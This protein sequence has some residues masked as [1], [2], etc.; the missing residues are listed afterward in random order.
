M[1]YASHED[2]KRVQALALRKRKKK[3]RDSILDLLGGVCVKCGFSDPR[4]LAID[5]CNGGGTAERKKCGGGYYRVVLDKI[6]AGS[7]DYQL[8]CCN[9]NQIKKVES[10]EERARVHADDAG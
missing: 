6:I 8:L 10:G 3:I 2:R 4:A 9:C 1:P 5:H 7:E